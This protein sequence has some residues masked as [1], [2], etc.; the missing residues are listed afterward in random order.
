M[1]LH[2]ILQAAKE[3]PAL[4][5]SLKGE[6]KS[7][8]Q[9]EF[10]EKVPELLTSQGK[11]VL[12]KTDYDKQ[13]ADIKSNTEAEVSSNKTREIAEGLERDI[14]EITGV[15]K[16]DNE[17]Y[18]DYQKR[19][20]SSTDSKVDIEA[21]KAA[22]LE[23]EQ[24]LNTKLSDLEGKVFNTKVGADLDN[25]FK[26]LNI[27]V[28]EYITDEAEKAEYVSQTE[29]LIK[30]GFLAKYKAELNENG[31]VVYLQ[32]GKQ[33][34]NT[35]TLK[36]LSANELLSKSSFKGF[37]QRD[38]PTPNGAKLSGSDFKGKPSETFK[39]KAALDTY[40]DTKH[41]AGSK[42]WMVARAELSKANNL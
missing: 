25:G 24:L 30:G 9:K 21:V 40:L 15:K 16:L 1:E 31:Q 19:V 29:E 12:N 26:G 39:D 36:P 13:L 3:N 10:L 28:P 37:F 2:E 8:I 27:A 6:L 41:K 14:F 17:K 18:Y 38:A 11:V 35:D 34:T 7:D 23:K 32:E 33:L 42:E 22:Y 20:Y 5:D 4:M